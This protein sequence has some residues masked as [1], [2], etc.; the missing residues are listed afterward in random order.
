[1]LETPIIHYKL[2]V[3]SSSVTYKYVDKNLELLPDTQKQLLRMGPDN[4]KLI[5]EKLQ[6][7]QIELERL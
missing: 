7:I 4:L 3:S 5:K 6:E 2:A 1:M